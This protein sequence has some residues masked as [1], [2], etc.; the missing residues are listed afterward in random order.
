MRAARPQLVDGCD[1]QDRVVVNVDIMRAEGP[2][3][4]FVY[5]VTAYRTIFVRAGTSPSDYPLDPFA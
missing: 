5:C 3:Y 1:I 2:L 4:H